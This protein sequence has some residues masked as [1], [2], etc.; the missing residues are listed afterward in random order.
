MGA[1][2]IGPLVLSGC[3]GMYGCLSSSDS[4]Q[5]TTGQILLESGMRV[6]AWEVDGCVVALHVGTGWTGGD[7]GGLG[8]DRGL[9][10]CLWC[11][12]LVVV[13]LLL[14]VLGDLDLAQRT[15]EAGVA[16]AHAVVMADDMS[17]GLVVCR[18]VVALGG[19]VAR[20][21]RDM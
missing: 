20:R 10:F 4:R 18:F 14:V 9:L 15:V 17:L 1:S 19:R 12:R 21:L 13:V 5:L 16:R 6:V 11:W 3:A 2:D 7:E 8:G